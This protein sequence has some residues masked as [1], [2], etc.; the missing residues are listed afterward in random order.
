MMRRMQGEATSGDGVQAPDDN[1]MTRLCPSW[2]CRLSFAQCLH[3][4]SIIWLDND[5][6]EVLE[7]RQMVPCYDVFLLGPLI[8]LD[9]SSSP[10]GDG[11]G[12]SVI[13]WASSSI[14]ESRCVK[15]R[16]ERARLPFRAVRI[17]KHS[18][19]PSEHRSMEMGSPNHST[20]TTRI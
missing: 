16:A 17:W 20:S 14:L 6:M 2:T 3:C 13:R 4:E 8:P 12:S 10:Y 19:F 1:A 9:T 5:L 7:Q 18:V 15:P 11:T